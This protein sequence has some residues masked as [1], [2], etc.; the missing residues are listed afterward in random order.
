MF[1]E[2]ENH[3]TCKKLEGFEGAGSAK[4]EVEFRPLVMELP[5][6]RLSIGHGGDT[7]K[8]A[9]RHDRF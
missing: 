9:L 8:A 2:I 1:E 3:F 6:A 5:A 4:Q 7:P